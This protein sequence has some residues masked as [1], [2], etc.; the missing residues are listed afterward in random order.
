ME[1]APVFAVRKHADIP[2]LTLSCD[3]IVDKFLVPI[4]D[5]KELQHQD[6]TFTQP[7]VEV[8]LQIYAITDYSVPEHVRVRLKR[9]HR[10]YLLDNHEVASLPYAEMAG[11]AREHASMV[12][13]VRQHD[14]V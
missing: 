12:F 6:V 11:L 7:N 5:N 14:M 4:I 8:K 13:Y 2:A 10:W 3:D 1:N 9:H